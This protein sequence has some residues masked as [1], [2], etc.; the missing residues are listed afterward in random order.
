MSFNG[1]MEKSALR[2]TTR[3]TKVIQKPKFIEFCNKYLQSKYPQS[4]E[5]PLKMKVPAN[6][7]RYLDNKLFLTLPKLQLKETS[8]YI[9]TNAKE[10]KEKSIDTL[11]YLA[12]SNL[13]NNIFVRRYIQSNLPTNKFH[14]YIEPNEKLFKAL[15]N[16][17]QFAHREIDA[18]IDLNFLYDEI[19]LDEV[20]QIKIFERIFDYIYKNTPDI[21]SVWKRDLSVLPLTDKIGL[22]FKVNEEADEILDMYERLWSHILMAQYYIEIY[23]DSDYSRLVALLEQVQTIYK[24]LNHFNKVDTPVNYPFFIDQMAEKL[25][26]QNSGNDA[27]TLSCAKAIVLYFFEICEFGRKLPDEQLS[28]FHNSDSPNDSPS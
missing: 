9:V 19:Y 12:S 6:A 18:S 13:Y 27:E 1:R 24:Q 23:F 22:N 4:K 17:N 3:N 11:I 14:I 8:N 21:S 16:N 10:V 25:V 15:L 28:I 20:H 2:H 7:L 5:I 26:P